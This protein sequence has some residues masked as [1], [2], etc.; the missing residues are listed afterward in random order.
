[1][2]QQELMQHAR[3]A[4]QQAYAPYSRF[5]V[6]AALLHKNGTVFTGGNVEA[7]S[8]GNTICAERVA[9][10]KAVSAGLRDGFVMLAVCADTDTPCTPCGICRQML[11][12]FAPDL[13]VVCAGRGEELATFSLQ[14]LLPHAFGASK[15]QGGQV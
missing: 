5:R 15:L 3:A 12:E 7:A 1:M 2:T 14:E 13:Q 8:Y 4:Q 11:L 9:L 10:C 6:G